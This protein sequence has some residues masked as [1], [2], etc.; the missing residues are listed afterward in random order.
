MEQTSWTS[1]TTLEKYPA[2]G[3]NIETD[4]VIIGAGITG[5]LATYTLLKTGKKVII[6]EKNRIASDATH[7]TT[8]IITQS[9]DTS[10]QDLISL[11]KRKHASHI[12]DSHMHAIDYIESIVNSEDIDCSFSRCSNYIYINN[13]D[14]KKHLHDEYLAMKELGIDA[15]FSAEPI[16]GFNNHGYIEL[17]NQAKFHPLKFMS[18]LL[19]V[20]ESMGG[21]IYEQ[22][23]AAEI[24]DG[25][26]D[27]PKVVLKNGV[28]IK[29]QWVIAAT[30][31]PFS[32]PLGMF[33]K[34]GMYIS[35]II[36]AEVTKGLIKEGTY[37]DTENPYHYFRIDPLDS[38]RDG[39]LIGGEDHRA[40]LPM[41][42]NKNF[43]ALEEYMQ[44]T[45]ADV[46][47]RI[48]N[49]WSGPILEPSD[50]LAL[51][52]PHKESHV[53]HA[54]G[55][56]G[57]GMTYS[58]ISSLIFR[59]IIAGIPSGR[60]YSMPE[61]Y[62]ASRYLGVKPLIHKAADYTEELVKGAVK[63]ALK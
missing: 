41:S 63:N 22:S 58:G 61:L 45:F 39:M 10:T 15:C 4:V 7:R 14:E 46:K 35:Y 9:I 13:E 53:L 17:K 16:P 56:S 51:I 19:N 28:N 38:E 27:E 44:K 6:V 60:G 24:K 36:E 21:Q 12:I 30:Y 57:N 47:Y 18:E 55:F 32:Q 1:D 2:L 5:I 34:K 33:F 42:E 50:G 23:E 52:G 29:A 25:N 3:D 54:T 20:I 37:E 62:A 49:R 26:T 59:E 40:E 8:A 31:E 43:Q 48:T 11:F